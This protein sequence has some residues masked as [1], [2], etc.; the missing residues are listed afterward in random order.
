MTFNATSG[1]ISR[2]KRA[3]PYPTRMICRK[4]SRTLRAEPLPLG[5]TGGWGRRLCQ[6]LRDSSLSMREIQSH[7]A[8]KRLTLFSSRLSTE[9]RTTLPVFRAV[10][11][12]YSDY[13]NFGVMRNPHIEFRLRFMV[14]TMPSIVVMLGHMDE[15]SRMLTFNSVRYDTDAYGKLS[16]FTLAKFL[17]S[18]HEKHWKE[19]P[20][21]KKYRGEVHLRKLYLDDIRGIQETPQTFQEKPA[22]K[23]DPDDEKAAT[24]VEITYENHKQFC[25]DSSLGLCVISYLDGRDKTSVRRS[26]R[27]LKDVQNMAEMDGKKNAPRDYCQVRKPTD[28][29]KPD[30][31]R[32]HAHTM[33]VTRTR[34]LRTC[35][36]QT[37]KTSTHGRDTHTWPAH[38]CVTFV[39]RTRQ[40]SKAKTNKS[41]CQQLIP[42]YTNEIH[43]VRRTETRILPTLTIGAHTCFFFLLPTMLSYSET[44]QILVGE[45]IV[46]PRI[47]RELR[48]ITRVTAHASGG[49]TEAAP[50]HTHESEF[51]KRKHRQLPVRCPARRWES[52]ALLE[53][54]RDDRRRMPGN[55]SRDWK[56][57]S[58]RRVSK[59][60]VTRWNFFA[61]V[62][63]G[64]FT[65]CDYIV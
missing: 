9:E 59:A 51:R 19:Q 15:K 8:L 49:E 55:A 22:P 10:A 20:N 2:T 63:R 41:Q 24:A 7:R 60:Y 35:A 48:R 12:K 58:A 32:E 30:S 21:A 43:V 50:V 57:G 5:E 39:Q 29:K 45:C 65:M 36:W 44:L 6:P 53:I 61:K 64:N 16:Y 47:W 18:V 31:R 28:T 11:L 38:M 1:T 56:R 54:Q 4:A 26:L 3:L 33:D 62:V 27:I 40:A 42:S 13:F 34:D 52:A 37:Y 25:S 46:S 23:P 17:F 14:E